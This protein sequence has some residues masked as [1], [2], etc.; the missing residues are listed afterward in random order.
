MYWDQGISKFYINKEN[1]EILNAL[2]YIIHFF[3]LL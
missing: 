2:I 1:E 3:Y